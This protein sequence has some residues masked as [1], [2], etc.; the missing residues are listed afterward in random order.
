MRT[1]GSALF[2]AALA[3][4]GA[5]AQAPREAEPAKPYSPEGLSPIPEDQIQ[6]LRAFPFDVVICKINQIP[7]GYVIIAEGSSVS[8]PGP[9]PNTWTIKQPG[10]TEVVCKV[11]PIPS[12]YVVQGQGSSV[13]CPGSFPNTW[14]IRRV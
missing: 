9:F 13:S 6:R 7:G 4:S 2:V 1:I 10:A 14:T 3:I 5:Y 12:N 11:S 8:C